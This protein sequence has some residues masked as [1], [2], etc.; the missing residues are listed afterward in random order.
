MPLSPTINVFSL[1]ISPSNLPSAGGVGALTAFIDQGSEF[2]GKLSFNETITD[3]LHGAGVAFTIS[4][5]FER[6][7]ELKQMVER[8]KRWRTLE[9]E[10]SYYETQWKPKSWASR[11]RFLFI[12]N[13]R[14][15]LCA[16][17]AALR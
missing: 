7:A 13:S 9:A 2:S 15:R 16:S 4:V 3:T 14:L 10:L 12:C 11:Y 5:P 8:R 6:F 1:A 17:M